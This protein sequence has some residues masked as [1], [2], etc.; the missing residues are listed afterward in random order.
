MLSG[1][2][3]ETITL[4]FSLGRSC[5][6]S[7]RKSR[8]ENW[9]EEVHYRRHEGGL[10]PCFWN[11]HNRIIHYAVGRI[12]RND[13]TIL[14]VGEK[15]FVKLQKKP[16][17]KL[18][19]RGPLEKTRGRSETL[20]LEFSN[21]RFRHSYGVMR[22]GYLPLAVGDK[23]ITN[24]AQ[25][26]C[27]FRRY[28]DLQTFAQYIQRTYFDGQFSP[29][30]WNVYMTNGDIRTNIHIELKVGPFKIPST[31]SIL[32]TEQTTNIHIDWY[33][34]FCKMQISC[35]NWLQLVFIIN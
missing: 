17:R 10:K 9:S 15:L 31:I 32:I 13:H 6:W 4:F 34:C 27:L 12:D 2:S 25:T 3:T 20:F 19:W 30:I 11:F 22:L 35:C 7:S 8:Q 28:P 1:G 26:R 29:V 24:C 18:D 16:T 23:T 14:L 5:L 33:G 21:Q